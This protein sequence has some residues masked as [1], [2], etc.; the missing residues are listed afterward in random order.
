MMIATLKIEP[1]KYNMIK[2]VDDNNDN[3]HVRSG[4]IYNIHL[5]P[6][7]MALSPGPSLPFFPIY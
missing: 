3:S 4:D 1:Q 7:L 2:V 5:Q 6:N